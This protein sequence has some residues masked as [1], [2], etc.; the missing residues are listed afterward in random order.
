MSDE[1]MQLQRGLE[2]A[3]WTLAGAGFGDGCRDVVE[4]IDRHRPAVVL[5]Q[6]KRDWDARNAGGCFNPHI[7]FKHLEALAAHDDIYKIA[8]I[9]DAASMQSYHQAFC[10]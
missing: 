9:K 1:G 6:D 2:A 10:E 8:V 4:L 3:G 5:V 7:T